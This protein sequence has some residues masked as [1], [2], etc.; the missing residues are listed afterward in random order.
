MAGRKRSDIP[1]E[2]A[3]ARDRFEIWRRDRKV[4]ARIPDRLWTL[5]VK[6]A[7][8]HGLSRTASA[9]KLDYQTLKERV[10]T[11]ASDSAAMG[12]AF[13]ELSPPSLAPRKNVL[14]KLKIVGV[15]AFAFICGAVTCR[16]SWLL[17][18]RSGVE[19]D[20]ANHPTDED[21]GRCRAGRFSKGN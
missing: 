8:T 7:E 4:G 10:G 20:A 19:G 15:P 17:A 9:L 5:A 21:S 2:L 18:R 3:R 14:S 1:E 11:K 16:T 13:I 12:G 6:L